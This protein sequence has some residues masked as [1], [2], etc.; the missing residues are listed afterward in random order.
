MDT[1]YKDGVFLQHLG[2]YIVCLDNRPN[3][4]IMYTYL[5]IPP[6]LILYRVLTGRLENGGPA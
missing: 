4:K 1:L 5:P 2:H 6:P 3:D